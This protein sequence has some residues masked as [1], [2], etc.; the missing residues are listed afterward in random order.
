[1]STNFGLKVDVERTSV[2]I[3]QMSYMLHSGLKSALQKTIKLML[4]D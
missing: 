2:R 3:V 4:T 1:M